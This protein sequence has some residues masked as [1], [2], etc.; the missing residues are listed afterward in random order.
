MEKSEQIHL[1]LTERE[2]TY[3]NLGFIDQMLHGSF[4]SLPRFIDFLT[5]QPMIC[6]CFASLDRLIDFL[7]E[8]PKRTGSIRLPERDKTL[9]R[10]GDLENQIRVHSPKQAGSLGTEAQ[11][12]AEAPEAE[13]RRRRSDER[14]Q[15]WVRSCNMKRCY[16]NFISYFLAK[17]IQPSVLA[18]GIV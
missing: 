7:C 18:Y 10:E 8:I 4:A 9:S 16:W 14:F 2:A 15:E 1:P 13:D 5:D 12:A 3:V 17:A 6:G 11:N